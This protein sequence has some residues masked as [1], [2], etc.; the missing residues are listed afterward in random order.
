MV[1][2][3][4]HPLLATAAV[5]SGAVD[6]DV[7]VDVVAVDAVE[8]AVHEAGDTVLKTVLGLAVGLSTCGVGLCLLRVAGDTVEVVG[9]E[10]AGLG[11]SNDVVVEDTGLELIR[12][13]ALDLLLGGLVVH[14]VAGVGGVDEGLK[15]L[16]VAGISLHDLLV[17]AESSGEL[18]L[19]N[20]VD[21]G[22]RAERVGD[23]SAKL[24]IAGLEDGLGG[25]V[26]DLL[27][28]LVVIHGQTAAGE[29][30]VDTLHLLVGEKTL[31]VGQG[32]GVGHVNGDGVSVTKGNL[33]GQ[34]VKR[35]PAVGDASMGVVRMGAERI[36]TC[37]RR[38]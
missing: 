6:G 1:V 38:Q 23:G 16:A 17:L 26:E 8:L 37:D 30:S 35:R 15:T 31:D 36:H 20:V 5:E 22:A 10:A 18:F 2:E 11:A 29:E 25:L 32:G 3:D 12:D 34:L 21:E 9:T 28:E 27:V 14:G 7:A 24:A 13:G 4:F 33:G 19:A